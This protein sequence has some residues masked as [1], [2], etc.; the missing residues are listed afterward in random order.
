[1]FPDEQNHLVIDNHWV[2][3]NMAP[4]CHPN[5]LG[6]L[7]EM[8]VARPAELIMFYHA[9]QVVLGTLKT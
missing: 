9:L 7:S 1:M 4:V 8:L 2:S 3:L 6:N 5:T